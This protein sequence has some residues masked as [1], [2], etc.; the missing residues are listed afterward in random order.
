MG[1][2]VAVEGTTLGAITDLDG[3]YKISNITE[4]KVNLVF[5]YVGYAKNLPLR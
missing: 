3:N 2:A 5:Q 4:G 1:V